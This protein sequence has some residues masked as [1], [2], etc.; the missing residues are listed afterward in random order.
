MQLYRTLKVL[1]R[2][3]YLFLPVLSGIGIYAQTV[4]PIVQNYSEQQLGTRSALIWRAAQY[5]NGLVYLANNDGVLVF[6]GHYWRLIPTPT[7]VRSLAVDAN[8][9][10]VGRMYFGFWE[11]GG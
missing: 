8:G 5:E 11:S 7:A 2:C 1:L 3:A 6:D 9:Q 4:E 10:G